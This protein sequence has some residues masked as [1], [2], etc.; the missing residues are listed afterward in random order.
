VIRQTIFDVGYAPV[1]NRVDIVVSPVATPIDLTPTAFV[2]VRDGLDIVLANNRRRGVEAPGGHIEPGETP[3]Q[4]AVR[5]CFEETG[6]EITDLKPVGHLMMMV[7]GERP[8]GYRYPYPVS[9]QQFFSARLVRA[10]PYC[11]NDECLQPVWVR[12]FTSMRPSL[13]I[14][15]AEVLAI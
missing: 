1:P 14:F 2:I 15:S 13:R 4:A 11:D 8:D 6:C 5:E 7:S 12:D 10:T 9:Y 3:E